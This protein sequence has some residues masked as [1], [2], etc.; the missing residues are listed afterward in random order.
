[1]TAVLYR[2]FAACSHVDYSGKIQRSPISN[3]FDYFYGISGSLDMP[4]Y[5][6]IENAL[7]LFGGEN[8]G[9]GCGH[10]KINEERIFF[11]FFDL[12]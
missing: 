8:R 12:F 11:L 1:M 10:W 4:P 7:E 5:I 6:Y 3:G 2:S 9:M